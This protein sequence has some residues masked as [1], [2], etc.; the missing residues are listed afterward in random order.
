VDLLP[1]DADAQRAIWEIVD[2]PISAKKRWRMADIYQ[3]RM[4]GVEPVLLEN[5]DFTV[6]DNG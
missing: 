3:R 4:M 1:T 2:W 5:S 6:T